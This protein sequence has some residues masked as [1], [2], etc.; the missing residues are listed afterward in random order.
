[1]SLLQISDRLVLRRFGNLLTAASGLA[2]FLIS[3]GSLVRAA[4]AGLSCPDWP[5]CFGELVPTFD[6]AIFLEWFH[7]LIAGILAIL[8]TFVT[9]RILTTPYLRRIL[10]TQISVAMVLLSIQVVLG[11][12]TVLKL[13]EAKTVSAH[14]LNALLFYAVLL[15][16]TFRIRRLA[17]APTTL[18]SFKLPPAVQWLFVATTIALFAQIA[19][20]GMVSSNFAGMVCP[21]FPKCHG[22]WIPPPLFPFVIQMLHRAAGFVVLGLVLVLRVASYRVSLPHNAKLAVTLV[23]WL[24]VGQIILGVVNV[25]YALPIAAS[26]AHLANAV[27]MY[28]LMI[29]GTLSV[30]AD[31]DPSDPIKTYQKPQEDGSILAEGRLV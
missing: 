3:L 28:T 24:V 15:W 22:E 29:L 8:M 25:V 14:L 2:F 20:G 26:S 13:L 30:F 17:A 27:A 1:M 31:A 18:K 16:M 4:Q 19:L 21:D 10:G 12:L 7:R 23:P 11:G 6:T 9:T 5:L